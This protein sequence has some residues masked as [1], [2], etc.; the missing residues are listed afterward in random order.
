MTK[1]TRCR[2]QNDIKM[3]LKEIGSCN[4]YYVDTDGQGYL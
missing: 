2:W 1:E 3:D 4:L